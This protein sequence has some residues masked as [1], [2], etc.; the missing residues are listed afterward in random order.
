MIT[1]FTESPT[2]GITRNPWDLQR[3]AGR[4][5]R[6]LGGGR[7]GRAAPRRR[8]APTAAARSGSRPPA[9]ACSGS[10]RERGRVPTAPMVEPWHGLSTWGAITR[11]VIDSARFY[12][13]IRDGGESFAEAAAREPGRLRIAVSRKPPPAGRRRGPTPSSSAALEGTADAAALARPRRRRPR[14]GLGHRRRLNFVPR[15]LRGIHDEGWT[16]EHPGAPGAAHPRLHAPRRPDPARGAGARP[17]AGGGR[18]RAHLPAC[19]TTGFDVVLHADVH[20]P[21]ADGAARTRAARRSGRST[22]IARFAPYQAIF[23]HTGQPAAAVPAGF[24]GDGFPLSVQLVGAARRRGRAA[25]ARRAA[26]ARA[27]L[28][29]A[30]PAG[31]AVSASCASSP[32]RSPARRAPSCWR[33]SPARRSRSR[34]RARRPTSSRRPTRRPRTLIRSRLRG[35]AARRRLPGGGGRRRDRLERAALDRRPAR[36]HDQLPVRH[37]AVGGLDRGRGRRRRARRRRLR[38]AARRAVV[39][40]A[41]R[42]GDCSTASPCAASRAHRAGHGADRHRASAT[43]PRC[44]ARRPPQIAALLPDVRDIRRFGA[45]ALDLAWC[46]AGRYDAY[47]ERGVHRWDVAAGS[48]ASASAP[49]WSVETLARGA[50]A[51]RRHPRRHAGADRHAA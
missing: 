7:R 35:R 43:T 25:L 2:W 32:R 48:A 15:Y 39:G 10:S 5:E 4:L 38:P 51:G 45:A 37:P 21:P 40:R 8:S 33:R 34:P 36:R 13:A 26:R 44:A 22:A 50:A 41:R 17:R 3:S 6:R 18:P 11:R 49:G 16:V 29:R 14:A 27:R 12:D 42:S 23:N 46:A 9:A 47:Y 28:A 30:P 24:A 1:P 20:P 31:D 19:S